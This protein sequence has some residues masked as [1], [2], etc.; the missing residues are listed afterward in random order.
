RVKF[1][2][3]DNDNNCIVILDS[4][5]GCSGVDMKRSDSE[6]DVVYSEYDFN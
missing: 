2:A 4:T 1:E 3:V 6:L 5:M